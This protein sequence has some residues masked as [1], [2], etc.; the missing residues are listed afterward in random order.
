MS[1]APYGGCLEGVLPILPIPANSTIT[2]IIISILPGEVPPLPRN[3]TLVLKS[4]SRVR[5]MLK[6]SGIQ[7]ILVI[8]MMI[9]TMIIMMIMKM[10]IMMFT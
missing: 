1:E 10:I 2:I 6:S 9:T 8:I 4:D 5:W 3:L 7:V